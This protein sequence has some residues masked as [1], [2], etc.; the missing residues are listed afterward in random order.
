MTHSLCLMKRLADI[1]SLHNFNLLFHK[2]GAWVGC[3]TK[4][5]HALNEGFKA[6]FADQR[7][8]SIPHGKCVGTY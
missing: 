8:P 4:M 3:T 5:R 7:R 6:L 1:P 2:S